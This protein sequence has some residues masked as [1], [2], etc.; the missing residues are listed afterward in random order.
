MI[1][2]QRALQSAATISRLYDQLMTKATTD[3]GRMG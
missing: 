1:T 2:M 3:I